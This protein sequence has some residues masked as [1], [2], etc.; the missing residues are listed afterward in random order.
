MRIRQLILGAAAALL[1]AGCASGMNPP[2][3][4]AGAPAGTAAV[5]QF[6]RLAAASDYNGMGWIF[7]TSDGP[8]LAR[9]PR[10][11]VEQR[12]FALA[13]ILEHDGFIVGNGS[14][15]PGRLNDAIVY[16]VI[17][18]RGA[19]NLTVPFTTVRGPDGRWFVEQ[20]DLEAVTG[21]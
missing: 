18:T 21:R 6:L 4:L 12:M 5:E 20:V 14:P 3:G 2:G 13:E 17:M 8:I 10:S 7:G 11:V 16:D 19:R 1:L 9:D 15:V